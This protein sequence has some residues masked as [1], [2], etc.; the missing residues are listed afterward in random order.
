[1]EVVHAGCQMSRHLPGGLLVLSPLS[2]LD[3]LGVR[4][5]PSF[6]EA[7][8]FLGVLEDQPA[9]YLLVF[10]EAPI[11]TSMILLRDIKRKK[12]KN[13]REGDQKKL[14]GQRTGLTGTA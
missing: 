8:P 6:L 11:E 14:G 3:F 2:P 4:L 9:P 1:M 12:K 7:H 5:L 10:L 13:R